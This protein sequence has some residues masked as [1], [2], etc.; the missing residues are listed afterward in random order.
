MAYVDS[1]NTSKNTYTVN[2]GFD[3]LG[4]AI[5]K[6]IST[7][8]VKLVDP[9]DSKVA[10]KIER[11]V[12]GAAKIYNTERAKLGYKEF[13]TEV[14]EALQAKGVSKKELED[15][16]ESVE[17]V[18]A[19]P[20]I[21][22]VNA[23]FLDIIQDS[24]ISYNPNKSISTMVEDVLSNKPQGFDSD[25]FVRI[26]K[27]HGVSNIEMLGVLMGETLSKAYRGTVYKSASTLGKLSGLSKSARK[28]AIEKE[29]DVSFGGNFKK[30]T[31]KLQTEADFRAIKDGRQY[32]VDTLGT[33]QLSKET[34][35]YYTSLLAETK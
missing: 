15:L 22:R 18:L 23:A 31:E 14:K 10:M 7:D 17:F 3:E 27:S 32:A 26:M 12:Q 16:D 19:E 2:V 28:I 33:T 6:E 5:T 13:Q 25:D 20:A 34:E 30:V 9:F 8:K 24:G 29:L 1:I 35:A 21:K 4:D 11:Q